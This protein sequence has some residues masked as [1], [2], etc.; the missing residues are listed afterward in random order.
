MNSNNG[1]DWTV[2]RGAIIVFTISLLTAIAIIWSTWYFMQGMKQKNMLSTRQ[3]QT[4]SNQY[5]DIDHEEKLIR[6]YY[7]EFIE[8]YEKGLLGQERRLNWIE[9]LRATSVQIK[10][11]AL[12]Y[13]IES[14]IQYKPDFPLKTGGYKLYTS[15]MKL[16]MDLLHIDDLSNLINGLENRALGSFSI[17]SCHLRRLNDKIS[18]TEMKPNISADCELK[19]Y[20]LKKSN[21]SDIT[22]TQS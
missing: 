13:D 18:V 17:T 12:K 10:L 2:L 20:N 14:Q 5:L 16:S 8:L 3:F 4:I 7:P 21:G 1:I 22:L 15:T 11:P 19:W 9:T 6:E